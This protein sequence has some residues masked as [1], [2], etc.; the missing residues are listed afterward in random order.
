MS[1]NS[2][3]NNETI[4]SA[5]GDK[6]NIEKYIYCLNKAG[7]KV[8]AVEKPALGLLRF[9]KT[10]TTETDQYLVINI[11]RDGIDLIVAQNNVLVFYDFSTLSEVAKYDLNSNLSNRDFLIFLNKK[12]GQVVNFCQARQ[13]TCLKK[14]F[15]FSIIPAIKTE[16]TNSLITSLGLEVATL[17]N[18]KIIK[19]SEE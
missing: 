12:V 8:I 13:N 19:I 11:D 7:F 17:K 10:F 16:I 5:V 18:D 14:F 4:F 3:T 6:L 2:N 9:L 1:V 15:L